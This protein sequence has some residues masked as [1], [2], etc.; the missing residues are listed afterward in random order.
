[1]ELLFWEKEHELMKKSR[2]FV[3]PLLEAAGRIEA[4][5]AS[6]TASIKKDMD[7]VIDEI[8]RAGG[9]DSEKGMAVLDRIA[10][11]AHTEQGKLDLTIL[12]LKEFGNLG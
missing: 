2:D 9:L 5:N 8:N 10:G 4:A 3:S 7:T 12:I 1:M 11:I 6:I